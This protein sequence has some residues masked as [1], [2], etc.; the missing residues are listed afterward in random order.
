M[1]MKNKKIKASKLKEKIAQY[2]EKSIEL[3][4][5]FDSGNPQVKKIYIKGILE[6]KIEKEIYQIIKED[7]K[8]IKRKRILDMGC[9]LG[10]FLEICQNKEV[11]AVGVEIDPHA[12]EIA[13]LRTGSDKNIILGDCEKLSFYNNSFDLVVSITVIEHVKNPLKYLKEARR[14]L[15]KNGKLIVFAPNYL[16]P[17]EGHYKLFWLPYLFPYTKSL[18]KLYLKTKNRNPKFV[19]FIN[20]R[21]TPNYLK[22]NLKK[23]GFIEIKDSSLQRFRRRLEKPELITDPKAKKTLIKIKKSAFLNLLTKLLI[24]FLKITKLY[25]PII[26]IAKK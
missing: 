13:K 11:R 16:F 3:S 24:P 25:H 18:F 19:D 10:S 4:G 6:N 17:W 14:V 15:K 2:F 22:R 21:I 26:L 5:A 20:F 8:N 23:I 7:V 12:V 1:L 9:G